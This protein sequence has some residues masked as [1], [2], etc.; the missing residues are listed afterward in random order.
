MNI[1]DECFR[2]VCPDCKGQ[3]DVGTK[4]ATLLDGRDL[5]ALSEEKREALYWEIAFNSACASI[6]AQKVW[7][8]LPEL[9]SGDVDRDGSDAAAMAEAQSYKD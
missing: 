3:Y 7:S 4:A 2:I 8:R 6:D 1:I 9:M 5:R